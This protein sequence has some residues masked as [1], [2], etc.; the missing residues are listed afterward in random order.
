MRGDLQP[1]LPRQKVNRVEVYWTAVTY[2]TVAIYFS[3]ALA[4]IFGVI[5]LMNPA[6]V[7]KAVARIERKISGADTEA[8]PLAPGPVRFVVV[9]GAVRVKKVNSVKWIAA[10]PGITLDKGDLIQ[11]GANGL[12]SLSFPD[13]T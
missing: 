12:A 10:E 1:G 6:W 5:Y 13:G 8:G 9:N 4:L 11:T 2:K 3:L 7:D